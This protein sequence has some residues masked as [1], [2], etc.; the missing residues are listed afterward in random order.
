M[1]FEIVLEGFIKSGGSN[2]HSF[3]WDKGNR[4]LTVEKYSRSLV[5]YTVEIEYLPSYETD[6]QFSNRE[7]VDV[8]FEDLFV[9]LYSKIPQ[10][11]G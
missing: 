5:G 2:C 4:Y 7:T 6:R 9:F 8:S 11:Q 10:E 1:S 3:Y